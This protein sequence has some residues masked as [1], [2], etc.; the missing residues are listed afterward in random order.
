M[1]VLLHRGSKTKRVHLNHG[2]VSTVLR[3]LPRAP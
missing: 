2:N 3:L 1:V